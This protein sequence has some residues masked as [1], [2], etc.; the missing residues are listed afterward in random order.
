MRNIL[1][2]T[3][4]LATSPALANIPEDCQLRVVTSDV[5]NPENP[6]AVADIETTGE[7]MTAAAGDSNPATA[8]QPP[9]D[10]TARL[11]ATGPRTRH[12]E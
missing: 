2:G 11:D 5:L 4:L 7:N 12:R 1:L 8:D 9:P 3:I 6:A 10:L